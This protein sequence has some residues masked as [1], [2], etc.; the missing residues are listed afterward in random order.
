MHPKY[1]RA[2]AKIDGRVELGIKIEPYGRFDEG[3]ER[4][5]CNQCSY[6][7]ETY[8]GI[9]AHLQTEHL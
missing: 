6:Q 8:R 9:D 3:I 5:C 4:F 1:R 7:A 2:N